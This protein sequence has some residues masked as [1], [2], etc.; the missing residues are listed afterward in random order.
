MKVRFEQFHQDTLEPGT[1]KLKDRMNLMGSTFDEKIQAQ[2]AEFATG[3][4]RENVI[5]ISE[6]FYKGFL[7]VT[8]WYW[9]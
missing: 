4:G 1:I 7:F 5:S 9:D 3:V 2:A 6:G 8:V